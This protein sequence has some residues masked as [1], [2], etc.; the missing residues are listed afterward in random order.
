MSA[1]ST[2]ATTPLHRLNGVNLLVLVIAVFVFHSSVARGQVPF[3]DGEENG[4]VFL[5]KS[6]GYFQFDV[7]D[8]SVR[9]GYLHDT[10]SNWI[11]GFEASGK[12]SGTRAPLLTKNRVAPDMKVGFSFGRKYLFADELDLGDPDVQRRLR[13]IQAEAVAHGLKPN[14]DLGEYLHT[15]PYDRLMLQLSYAYKQYTLFD[16]FA[17]FDNQVFK[18]GFHNPSAAL[19]YSA[20]LTGTNFFGASFGV[21]R[22]NN[23]N[24]LTEVDVHDINTFAAGDTVREVVRNRE[25]LRGDFKQSTSVFLNTDYVW[26]PQKGFDRIGFDFYTRS[27]F[28]GI[29]QGFRPGFGVFLSEKGNPTKVLGGFTISYDDGKPSVALVVGFSFS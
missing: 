24:D 23:S 6:G 13:E 15:M 8:P 4:T 17:A 28:T 2:R 3:S 25:V 12:L 11:F 9:L 21:G 22:S 16:E 20:L 29:D 26:Y 10:P 1:M 14:D 5:A 18:K 27:T 19:T 7:A